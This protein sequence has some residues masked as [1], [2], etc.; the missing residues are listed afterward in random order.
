[1]PYAHELPAGFVG[2][3]AELVTLD[4]ALATA[5]VVVVLVDH[6]A[7]KHLTPAD[8]AGK[9]VFDTRGMLKR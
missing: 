5:K 1:E 9:L 2:T 6:T 4:H 7:F 3:G 8:L